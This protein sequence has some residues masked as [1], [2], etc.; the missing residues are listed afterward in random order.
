MIEKK[1][2]PFSPSLFH[3][4]IDSER[5]L[6]KFL[7]HEKNLVATANFEVH[8][9]PKIVTVNKCKF[10]IRNPRLFFDLE[11]LIHNAFVEWIIN[12]NLQ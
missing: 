12:L 6:I 1:I 9:N 2:D 5:K 10:F 7:D 3:S 8:F 11:I 4:E